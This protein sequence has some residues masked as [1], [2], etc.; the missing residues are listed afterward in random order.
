MDNLLPCNNDITHCF[1]CGLEVPDGFSVCV[2]IAGHSRPVC[3]YGCEAVARTIV[4]TGNEEYYRHRTRSATTAGDIVPEFLEQISLYDNERLQK[5]FVSVTDDDLAQVDLILEGINCAACLWLNQKHLQSLPGVNQATINYS[6]H[7]AHVKWD[8]RQL[9]LSEII[10]AVARIG[11]RAHPYDARRYQAVFK[12][13]KNA[14]LKRMGLAYVL[15]MQLM[16]IAVALYSGHWSGMAQEHNEM[17][18]WL[19]FLLALPILL[20]SGKPFYE[21]AWKDIRHRHAGVDVPVTI[22]LSI[23]M[24]ASG[25]A[26]I[27]GQGE[28]YFDS[29][30]MFIALLLTARYLEL[31]TRY[32]AAQA[33]QQFTQSMPLKAHRISD[34]GTEELVTAAD[35]NIGD[36]VRVR[37][38]ET[39]P[40]DAIVIEGSSY[41][42]ESL[43]SG[44]SK[45]VSKQANSRVIGGTVNIEG[46]LVIEV[47]RTFDNSVFSSITSMIER[48]HYD[49]P[50]WTATVDKIAPWFVLFVLSAAVAVALYWAYF[51]TQQWVW[52][53]VSVLIVSCPCALSLA[54]P[55]A[56]SAATKGLMSRGI[57]VAT[58]QLYE[59]L[60]SAKTF[61]FD[62]TGTLTTASFKID[63]INIPGDIPESDLLQIAAS[64]EQYSGHPLAQVLLDE[65]SQPL[66]EVSNHKVFP[67]SGL[68]GEID[69]VT[70]YIGTREYVLQAS[71]CE[72]EDIQPDKHSQTE[73]WIAKS[74]TMLACIT[75]SDSLRPDAG[76]LV[77]FLQSQGNRVVILSGDN[78]KTVSHIAE[79]LKVKEFLADMSPQ[80]KLEYIH[81]LQQQGQQV[82]MAGDGVNDAPVLKQADVSLTLQSSTDL[83]IVNS[84]CT[85]LSNNLSRI[86][87]LYHYAKKTRSIIRQN[88][89]WAIAYNI[90]AL[91]LAASGL[92]YPWL[93]ASGMAI[94][95]FVVT[96]NSMRLMRTR[97]LI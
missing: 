40:S 23:A 58:P 82:V 4:E 70:Y 91:P 17:F 94:S 75:M 74:G 35:L 19:S 80:D 73:V 88:I 20:Y 72:D 11:Y 45:P 26:T 87:D 47:D 5:E 95:S 76:Q 86:I 85:I 39:I 59:V 71:A 49:K 18:R 1:H 52:V 12:K 15:G 42:N 67:G 29:V 16:I 63:T 21:S 27:S 81:A 10:E 32:K 38:G 48:A 8:L 34:N 28:V 9:K 13:Q 3:C 37:P 31:T 96:I 6:T 24:L 57:L 36:R 44:E 90:T 50:A 25:I 97:K 2:E 30:A 66:L 69:G 55:L 78:H 33:S 60:P 54:T 79:L 64:I 61:V 93:A 46:I 84:D 62:K 51:H 83:A 77:K 56:I 53:T 92:V 22:G 68:S 14:F 41:A 7:R 65:N 89:Y 43:V